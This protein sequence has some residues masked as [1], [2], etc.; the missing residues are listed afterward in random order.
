M[1]PYIVIISI[2]LVLTVISGWIFLDI[3]K[4]DKIKKLPSRPSESLDANFS[5]LLSA[6]RNNKQIHYKP[7][8]NMCTY[9]DDRYDC[10]DL[11][12]MTRII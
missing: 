3:K 2:I 12:N 11:E 1:K 7:I 8:D 5:A 4:N 9:V 10:S 6:L